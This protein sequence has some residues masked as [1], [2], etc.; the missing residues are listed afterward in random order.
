MKADDRTTSWLVRFKESPRTRLRLFCFPY[1]GGSAHVFRQWPQ[2]P[3]RFSLH[4][5]PGEH[6][7]LHSSQSALLEIAAREL[8]GAAPRSS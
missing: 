2:S 8:E 3:V 6:F 5:L 7:F 4:M 1:A